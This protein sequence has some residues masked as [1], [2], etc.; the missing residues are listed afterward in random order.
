M[1]LESVHDFEVGRFQTFSPNFGP[2]IVIWEKEN[3]SATRADCAHIDGLAQDF[4]VR[5]NDDPFSSP[6]F[7][8]PNIIIFILRKVVVMYLYR[9]SFGRQQLEQFFPSQVSVQEKD[10]DFMRQ[11]RTV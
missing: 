2:C 8:K 3:P 5:G 7:G 11:L 4:A 1:I 9:K 10:W 6:A